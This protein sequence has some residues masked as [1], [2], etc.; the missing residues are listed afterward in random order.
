M[1][2]PDFL[3]DNARW[4]GAG[5]LLTFFSSFGQ[6]FFISIYSEQ[7]RTDFSL[8]HAGW[9]SLYAIATTAS[10]AV[11]VWAG[12]L[13]DI[14]RVRVLGPLVLALLAIAC[15]SMA[16]APAAWMLFG[17][18]FLLRFSGQGMMSHVAAVAMTRWFVKTRGKALSTAAVGFAIGEAILPLSFVALLAVLGWRIHWGI[19]ATLCLLAIPMLLWLLRQ[20]RTPQAIAKETQSVGMVGHHW[21]RGQAIKHPLFWLMVPTL[22]G[23]AAFVTAFF[24]QQVPLAN[25]KGWAHIELVALF[26]LYT[27]VSIGATI[28]SGVLIDK[29]GTARMI[30]IYQL[31]M[32]AAFTM[33]SVAQTPLGA[34]IGVALMAITVGAN[35]TVPTAFWAEFYGTR[36]IGGIKSMAAAIMVLGSAIGP[37]LTGFLLDQGLSLSFQM[38]GFAIYFLIASGLAAIG[39]SRARGQLPLAA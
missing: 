13:T 5:V 11:M 6:T 31:P 9:G 18:I 10:A 1:S 38:L 34:A 26:P 7:I 27:L 25:E 23:P 32:V 14:F 15:L 20:E 21:T 12:I 35:A 36:F 24:F 39:I 30:P 29:F 3:R 28:G 22:L 17:V 8:S 19:C 4:L 37:G 16:L 33:M 2:V